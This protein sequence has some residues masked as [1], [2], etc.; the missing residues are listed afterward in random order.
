LNGESAKASA[1]RWA[2]VAVFA[3]A[4][5][6]NYLDRLLLAN[7]APAIQAEFHLTNTDYSWLLSA[8]A[9]SYA[10]AS[11]FVGWFLD[12]VGLHVGIVCAVGLWSLATA[13]TGWSSTFVQ[14]LGAR[15]L[16]GMWESAGVPAAGKLNAMYL[17]PKHRALGAAVTQVGLTIG[18]VAAARLAK[19]FTDWRMPF[20]ICCALGL[21]WIPLWLGVKGRV[22]TSQDSAPK[23]SRA[24]TL[25]LL[26]DPRLI[27]LS[28]A[29]ILWMGIYTLA[30]NW[31]T[32]FLVK[33][34]DLSGPR[35]NDFAWFP[36]I[37]STLGGFFG[38]WL[39]MRRIHRGGD[40]VSARVSGIV[41]SAV[42]CLVMFA[43]PLMPSP[44]WA[45]LAIS[46]GYFWVTSGSVNMYTI[47][48]DIWGASAAGTAISALVFSCRWQSR[49]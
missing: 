18:S 30:S 4:S 7:S 49:L 41:V 22:S 44:L 5:T 46:A 37:A 2:V 27:R 11:P 25:A 28:F 13:L 9:L 26:R 43:V 17:L 20:F 15:V 12:R 33:T 23:R 40:P 24:D 16:L 38:G 47:P 10:L 42:G 36:P 31:T 1:L 14:L 32:L 29:N 45:T 8:F 21:M 39:S 3:L 19:A 48:V 35:A 6:W 34:Y